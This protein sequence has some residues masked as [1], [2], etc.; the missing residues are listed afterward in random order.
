MP[1]DW[2]S[3]YAFLLPYIPAEL[4]SDFT[5]IGTFV[6]A[7]CAILAR[8]W[9]RPKTGSRWMSLYRLVNHVAMNSKHAANADDTNPGA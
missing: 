7:L 4:A 9:P 6:I 5:L 1:L 8:F 3:F 2:Q